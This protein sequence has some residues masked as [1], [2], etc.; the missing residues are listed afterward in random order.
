M[1]L[2]NTLCR[3]NH[4]KTYRFNLSYEERSLAIELE[5]EK[6]TLGTAVELC[7]LNTRYEYVSKRESKLLCADRPFQTLLYASVFTDPVLQGKS[8]TSNYYQSTKLL[9]QALWFLITK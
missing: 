4:F 6:F 1:H 3:S 7:G 8:A 5:G 2:L 9:L